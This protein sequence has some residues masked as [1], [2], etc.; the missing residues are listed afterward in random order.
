MEVTLIAN[1]DVTVKNKRDNGMNEKTPT[2]KDLT[3]KSFYRVPP[4]VAR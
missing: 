1:F 3:L 2:I 4:S